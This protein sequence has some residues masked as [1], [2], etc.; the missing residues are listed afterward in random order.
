[1]PIQS[2]TLLNK[3]GQYNDVLVVNDNVIF[4]FPRYAEGV[5]ALR[6]EVHI[7]RR[8]QGY[9]TLPVPN[10]TFTAVDEKTIGQVFMGY[11]MIPGAP[12]WQETFRAIQDE[13]TLQRLAGQLA[14]FLKELHSIPAGVVGTDLPV[15][16]TPAEWAKLYAEIR[17]LLFPFMRPDAREW[18]SHHFETYLNSPHWHVY[19][20]SLRHGDFG[21]GN[22]L[23][24]REN[25]A[26]SGII[27]FGFAG[28]GDPALDIAAVSTLG[29]SFFARFYETYPEIGSMLER[30]HFYRGTYAL[31]EALHGV[32][33][34]DSEA[35]ESGIAS[36]I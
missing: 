12:L 23:Y 5:E 32:K 14:G 22:I 18:A 2:T 26:I 6:R 25:Q 9:I 28:L 13:Q 20:P 27:D 15:N 21:T 29:E 8:I 7:L 19:Q 30:A 36:Y 4:R 17:S 33:Y 10:P 11:R 1:M 35:F 3:E 16:D 24:D 31:Y 34:R